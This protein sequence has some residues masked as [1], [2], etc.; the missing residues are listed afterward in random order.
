MT[1]VG[2]LADPTPRLWRSYYERMAPSP[3][4]SLRRV[5]ATRSQT[6][7]VAICVVWVLLFALLA[8]FSTQRHGHL[9]WSIGA[10]VGLVAL[11]RAWSGGVHVDPDGIKVVGVLGS[12]RV[13]WSDAERFAV[14]PAGTR[15]SVTCSSKGTTVRCRSLP[16]TA[17]TRRDRWINST[18]SLRSGG[19]R[20]WGAPRPRRKREC[21]FRVISALLLVALGVTPRLY[22][23]RV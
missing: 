15:R 1:D 5:Y 18:N 21:R 4:P 7:A 3:K 22:R 17:Q 12:R 6:H 8:V 10:A 14:L 19:R 20:I 2:S 9:A 16:S 11:W 13:E 23:G